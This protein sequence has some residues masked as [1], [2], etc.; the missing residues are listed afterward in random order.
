[1]GNG[2]LLS[3]DSRARVQKRANKT[4]QIPPV[5]G[6]SSFPPRYV[7]FELAGDVIIQ[8][9]SREVTPRN[10]ADPALRSQAFSV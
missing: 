8:I 9:S 2:V 4:F 3:S 5:T 1:M 6:I 7:V 10:A